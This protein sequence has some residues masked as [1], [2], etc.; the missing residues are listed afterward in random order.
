M[1]RN[2]AGLLTAAVLLVCTCSHGEPQMSDKA[3]FELFREGTPDE[4]ETAI[5]HGADINR[6]NEKG[7]TPL[8]LAAWNQNSCLVEVLVRAG[9]DVNAKDKKGWT[10]LHR[11]M[12]N[13]SNTELVR[14]L[15]ESGANV[16]DRDFY[17]NTPL[18]NAACN[19]N[20]DI[21]VIMM[22]LKAGA[23]VNARNKEGETPLLSAL[24]SDSFRE[25]IFWEAENTENMH[26]NIR[27]FPTP[28][29]SP[30]F[31]SFPKMISI[32]LEAGADV[33]VKDESGRTLL[34]AAAKETSCPEVVMI[35]L[36]FGA[37]ATIRD[38]NGMR[39]ID[40]AYENEKLKKSDAYRKLQEASF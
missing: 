23:D 32:L 33:N 7:E 30:S 5:K 20:R 19:Y 9:A 12:Q 40:Y 36:K 22:L 26:D 25:T 37:D 21:E 4:I 24:L 34:H 18:H 2:V 16:N 8:Q 11:A 39:P 1:D 6:R 35:L 3:F 27:E 14:I 13:D 38:K 10:A 28:L 15:L 29:I 31:F 17:G